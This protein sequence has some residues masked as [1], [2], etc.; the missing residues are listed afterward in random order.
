[1]IVE[2]IVYINVKD[3]TPFLVQRRVHQGYLLAP[4][5]FFFI[6]E[7]LNVAA[8]QLQ[9][10]SDFIG[11]AFPLETKRQLINQYANDVTFSLLGEERFFKSLTSL[12]DRCK[13]ATEL[14]I[15]WPKSLGQVH[16]SCI[17]CKGHRH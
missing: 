8:K 2:A 16:N 11:I 5:L 13:E 12:M 1:V 15:N 7:A 9:T 4:Y 14:W 17:I 6:E 3:S 10:K